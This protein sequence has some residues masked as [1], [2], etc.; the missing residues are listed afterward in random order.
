VQQRL[1]AQG[2]ETTPMT[3]QELRQYTERDL[4]R[5]TRLVERAGIKAAK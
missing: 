3:P 1:G 2:L 5:W 4:D